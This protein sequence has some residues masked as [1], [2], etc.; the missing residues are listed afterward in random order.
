MNARPAASIEA[1]AL[2]KQFGAQGTLALE[3]VSLSIRPG[4]FVSG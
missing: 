4:E 2:R 3:D 1:K